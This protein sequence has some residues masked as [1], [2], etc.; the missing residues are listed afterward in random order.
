MPLSNVVVPIVNIFSTN[1]Y[2][3]TTCIYPLTDVTLIAP[4]SIGPFTYNIA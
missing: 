4:A 3:Q 2:A 1:T